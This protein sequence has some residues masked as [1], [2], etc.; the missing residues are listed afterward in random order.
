MSSFTITTKFGEKDLRLSCTS[1]AGDSAVIKGV[2]SPDGKSTRSLNQAERDFCTKCGFKVENSNDD[3][4]MEII[5]TPVPAPMKESSQPVPAEA[6]AQPMTDV[7]AKP[8]KPKDAPKAEPIP[9]PTPPPYTPRKSLATRVMD[10]MNATDGDIKIPTLTGNVVAPLSEEGAYLSL[11]LSR[12]IDLIKDPFMLHSANCFAASVTGL[13]KFEQQVDATRQQLHAQLKL[14][15]AGFIS[16]V[17]DAVNAYERNKE[18]EAKEGAGKS[19][20]LKTLESVTGVKLQLDPE[21]SAILAK[22]F[23]LTGGDTVQWLLCLRAQITEKALCEVLDCIKVCLNKKNLSSWDEELFSQL[24]KF[25]ATK[26]K[27]ADSP[28]KSWYTII[29]P[30]QEKKQSTRTIPLSQVCLLFDRPV[31]TCVHNKEVYDYLE[32]VTDTLDVETIMYLLDFKAGLKDKLKEHVDSLAIKLATGEVKTIPDVESKIWLEIDL[33]TRQTKNDA[34]FKKSISLKNTFC[35]MIWQNNIKALKPFDG[36]PKLIS[37]IGFT[38]VSTSLPKELLARASKLSENTVR[39]LFDC[40]PYIPHEELNSFVG[41]MLYLVCN[42]QD[43]PIELQDKVISRIEGWSVGV[44]ARA[45]TDMVTPPRVWR[46]IFGLTDA[47]AN[48][49]FVPVRLIDRVIVSVTDVI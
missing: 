26:P 10:I 45:K 37:L 48:K 2:L 30:K 38:D 29:K 6:F 32:S 17:Q 23:N 41:E 28:D 3:D 22:S 49:S 14:Q 19:D 40:Y 12:N 16:T 7:K 20:M 8:E 39:Y 34:A 25:I 47:S 33:L 42:K 31:A 4:D 24:E 21:I 44:T 36:M 11:L 43:V 1:R 13:A 35:N 46:K 18:R 5:E 27:F 9:A 15:E